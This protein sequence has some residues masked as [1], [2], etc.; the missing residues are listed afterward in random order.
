MAG[1]EGGGEVLPFTD[2]GT[3]RSRFGKEFGEFRGRHVDLRSTAQGS[4]LARRYIWEAF[5]G[6][7]LGTWW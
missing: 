2:L 6:G 1:V 3:M 5:G 4:H 7:W